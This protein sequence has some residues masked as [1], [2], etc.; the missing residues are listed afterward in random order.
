VLVFRFNVPETVIQNLKEVR[1][2][3]KVGPAALPPESYS[4]PGEYVYSR[5][6]PPEAVAGD[7]A[8]VD[9]EL[10]KYLAA[11]ASDPRELGVVATIIGFEVR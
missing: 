3:A 4:K 7:S 5:I 1:L 2:T 8:T 6:V 11:G 10:D 9:F